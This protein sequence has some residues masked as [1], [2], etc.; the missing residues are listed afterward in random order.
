MKIIATL[1][2]MCIN[3]ASIEKM[4]DYGTDGFC[5]DMSFA[6]EENVKRL[7][8]I[9]KNM[10]LKK[11]LLIPLI[12]ILKGKNVRLNDF[13]ET[14]IKIQKNDTIKITYDKSAKCNTSFLFISDRDFVKNVQKND[15]I[16]FDTYENPLEVIK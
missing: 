12:M 14:H 13:E 2:P 15:I 1:S 3:E 8:E 5:L 10:E 6:T 16:Y 4:I 9:R 7:N 11:N